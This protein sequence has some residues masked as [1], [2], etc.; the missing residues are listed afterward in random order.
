M[1]D[2]TK[3]T[4]S[5][6]G[7]HP[8]R[9]QC[10]IESITRDDWG[11]DAT[12]VATDWVVSVT[13]QVDQGV[14]ARCGEDFPGGDVL[15]AGSR[16][17]AC[18]CIPV[19]GPCGE[20][21]ANQQILGREVSPVWKWPVRKSDR[22]KRRN[23]VMEHAEPAILSGDTILTEHGATKVDLTPRSGGWAQY[24][25]DDSADRREREG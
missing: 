1:S 16:L 4:E 8:Y 7:T 19:C 21:E 15:P 9:P 23:K 25:Y 6:S 20:D 10:A 22:T 24:G 5:Y 3:R 2:E 17:T 12:S 14:C 11:F 18:R 13:Q